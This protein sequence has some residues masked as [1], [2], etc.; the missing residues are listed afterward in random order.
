MVTFRRPPLAR[1]PQNFAA[2]TLEVRGSWPPRR[3][4]PTQ[5]TKEVKRKGVVL[6]R[7]SVVKVTGLPG[8]ASITGLQEGIGNFKC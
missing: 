3:F 5:Q 8:E 7:Q 6:K 4:N 1:G 2:K